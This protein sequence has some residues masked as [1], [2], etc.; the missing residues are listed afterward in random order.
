LKLHFYKWV[1]LVEELGQGY[2]FGLKIDSTQFQTKSFKFL[3]I[4]TPKFSGLLHLYPFS[5]SPANRW[6]MLQ[7]S[8]RLN[9][10]TE[11][12]RESC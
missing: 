2:Q 7:I 9:E 4:F 6:V 11:R 8:M 5:P 3:Q 1:G 12:E 10:E